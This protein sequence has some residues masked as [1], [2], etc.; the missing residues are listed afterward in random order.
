MF[1]CSLL[2]SFAPWARVSCTSWG[3]QPRSLLFFFCFFIDNYNPIL[4][5]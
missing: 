4:Y 1:I 3:H 2:G 5:T